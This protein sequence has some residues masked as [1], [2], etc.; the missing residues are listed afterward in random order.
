MKNISTAMGRILKTE[1]DGSCDT[2]HLIR[3]NSVG[4][5]GAEQW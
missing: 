4:A 2:R 5:R 3:L 1:E